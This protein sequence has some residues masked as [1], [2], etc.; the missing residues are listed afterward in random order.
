[1]SS[2]FTPVSQKEPE[3]T[4]WRVMNDTLLLARHKPTREENDKLPTT[5][6]RRVAA[7][8][9][10]TVGAWEREHRILVNTR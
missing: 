4:I 2:F 9:L 7:F 3:K 1:V 6:R 10:V 5:K 8:D